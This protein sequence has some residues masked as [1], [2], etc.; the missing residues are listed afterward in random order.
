MLVPRIQQPTRYAVL[1]SAAIVL[2][3]VVMLLSQ[4]C[5]RSG[6][7]DVV[8]LSD[9]GEVTRAELDAYVLTMPEDRRRPAEGQSLKEWRIALAGEMVV[10]GALATQG[11]ELGADHGVEERLLIARENALIQ[12]AKDV[13]INSHV[14][15]DEAEIRRF[16]DENPDQFG[17]PEQI[18]LRHIYRRVDRDA[19]AGERAAV[20]REMED[21]LGRLR[22]GAHF[23]DL[24]RE[25]SDSE[26]AHI[27]GLI[28]RMSRG[29]L[30]PSLEEIVWKL[31]EGEL[32]EVVETAVGFH[33]FRL[34][35][36]LESF[37][38]DF[39]DARR[40]LYRRFNRDAREE[41]EQ[42][43]FDDLL[44]ESRALY[45]PE[46]LDADPSPAGEEAVFS[47]GDDTMV[48]GDVD[49]YRRTAPFL[50]LRERPAAEWLTDSVRNRLLL[51]YA[52]QTDLASNPNIAAGIERAEHQAK[53]RIGAEHYLGK[54]IDERAASG[55]LE[56]YYDAHYKRFQTPKQY[57][58]RLITI[59]FEGYDKPYD[60]F[61]YLDRVGAEISAG[62]R[63]MA[64]EAREISD[65]PSAA[66]GGL[67]PW[68]LTEGLAS[69]AGPRAQHEVLAL[70]EGELSD[71]ILIERYDR[72]KLSY[73][74]QGYMLVRL[75]GIDFPSVRTFE[76]AYESVVQRY[77]DMHRTE[78]EAETREEIFA[79]VHAEVLEENL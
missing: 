23:G 38:M 68:M 21:M 64:E 41:L 46:L 9:L 63:D 45:R 52:R 50:M 24:A 5:K 31:D 10:V 3:A 62:I 47:L 36:R 7:S 17:H 30:D 4:A 20:R 65:D 44:E 40:R 59:G 12:A 77:T 34:D 69:W 54:R 32:S 55:A 37:H 26:T 25:H 39:E 58:L 29:S 76:E 16:Y 2:V 28:G 70:E 66:D 6:R 8:A 1:R 27:D 42:E 43:V 14:E 60:V 73:R 49:A 74:R 67:T 71:P 53:V 75:E 33:I 35:D 51:W 19:S 22:N 72:S 56:E 57:Q 61:E 18:R 11:E 78:L 79:A 48:V 15:T 13:L